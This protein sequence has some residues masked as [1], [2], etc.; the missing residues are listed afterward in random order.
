MKLLLTCFALV[1]LL[2]L[3]FQLHPT[4]SAQ[5]KLKDR[6]ALGDPASKLRAGK[7]K[8]SSLVG[9][10]GWIEAGIQSRWVAKNGD[11][12]LSLG[13]GET[14]RYMTRSDARWLTDVNSYFIEIPAAK[15][16]ASNPWMRIKEDQ[17]I[18]GFVKITYVSEYHGA[19]KIGPI[20]ND[21]SYNQTW[22]FSPD[23]PFEFVPVGK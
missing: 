9:R 3:G 12:V 23:G 17:G 21:T 6:L 19:G 8:D 4:P 16:N 14:S 15:A 7:V 1:P 18:R 2:T 20:Y 13:V 22:R 10:R 11:V 5:F